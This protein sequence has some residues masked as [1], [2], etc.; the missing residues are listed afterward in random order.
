MCRNIRP[1]FN[2]EPPVS[3]DEIAAAALQFV[4]KISGMTRPSQANQGVFDAAV[5]DIAAVSSRLLAEL[6]TSAPA[7]DREAE[8]VKAKAR[9]ASRFA[10]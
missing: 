4:R 8:A 6:R 1:L 9:A 3:E 7:R 2:L 5:A 10:R